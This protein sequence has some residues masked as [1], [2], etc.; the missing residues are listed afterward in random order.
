VDTRNVGTI[1]D[2]HTKR[3]KSWVLLLTF[4]KFLAIIKVEKK[5]SSTFLTN[6]FRNQKENFFESSEVPVLFFSYQNSFMVNTI[7]EHGWKDSDRDNR[8]ARNGTCSTAI[9]FTID[10]L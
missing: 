2:V 10:L 1:Y 7:M 3:S 9:F 8:N 4:L 6:S 5:Y